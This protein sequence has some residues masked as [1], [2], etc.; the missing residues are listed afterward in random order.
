MKLAVF[1]VG[2]LRRKT[3]LTILMSTLFIFFSYLGVHNIAEGI[4]SAELS[5]EIYPG[6]V[7]INDKHIL[8]RF[9]KALAGADIS[10]EKCLSPKKYKIVVKR[11]RGTQL[12]CFDEP[13]RLFEPRTGKYYLLKDKGSCLSDSLKQLELKNPFGEFLP[14]NEVKNIFKRYDKARITDFETGISF[15]VQRRAGSRHADVQPLTAD[16]SDAM[17]MIYGGKWSWKRRAVIVEIKGRRIAGSMNGMPHG[18]GAIGGNKFKG[19]FCIHF[20]DSQLHSKR[21]DLAHQLMIWK[22]AGVVDKMLQKAPPDRIFAAALTAL[23]QGDS[24][25]ALKFIH[26]SSATEKAEVT[27][28]IQSIKWIT[29]A[30]T[31]EKKP[32][33]EIQK[34]QQSEVQSFSTKVSYRLANGREYKNRRINFEVIKTPGSIPWKL[35]ADEVLKLGTVP[36]A[37]EQG[38]EDSEGNGNSEGSGDSGDR[39]DGEESGYG[40]DSEDTVTL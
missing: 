15:S 18:A 22:A 4:I 32:E 13:S 16:D 11:K 19:H 3:L 37:D 39:G 10:E 1:Q 31:T 7:T 23:E 6:S 33:I 2:S 35:K 26:L 14:W 8:S 28:L 12:F 9:G 24:K 36:A 21:D 20:R 29:V 34:K 17:K 5:S 27:S 40:G 25:L 30:K 38:T